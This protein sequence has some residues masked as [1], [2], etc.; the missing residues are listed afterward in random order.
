MNKLWWQNKL[1]ANCTCRQNVSIGKEY[2]SV[3]QF[4]GKVM[5]RQSDPDPFIE[6]YQDSWNSIKDYKSLQTFIGIYESLSAFT[7]VCTLKKIGVLPNLCPGEEP[8]W[9]RTELPNLKKL[10]NFHTV[11]KRGSVIFY[12]TKKVLPLGTSSVKHLFCLECIRVYQSL[13]GSTWIY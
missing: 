5:C 7:R 13:P 9:F 11:L 12:G 6:I 4:V 1:S 10:I 2:L 8:F 3:K